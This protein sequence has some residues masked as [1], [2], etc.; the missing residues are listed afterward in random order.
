M[1]REARG[2]F[3]GVQGMKKLLLWFSVG[4]C[5]GVALSVA[6]AYAFG[7]RDSTTE[8]NLYDGGSWTNYHLLWHTWRTDEPLAEHTKW[9]REHMLEGRSFRRLFVCSSERRWFEHRELLADGFGRDN[10]RRIYQLPVPEQDRIELLH[11][12]QRYLGE[13]PRPNEPY[14]RLF[15]KWKAELAPPPSLSEEEECK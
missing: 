10:V 12:Y 13:L 2:F 4:L 1:E 6:A 15:E 9:A 7:P 5:A 11:E 3:R 8:M 14:G